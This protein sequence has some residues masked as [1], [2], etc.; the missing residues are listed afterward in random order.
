MYAEEYYNNV[1]D[2]I[3]WDNFWGDQNPVCDGCAGRVNLD[4]GHEG[5]RKGRRG[6]NK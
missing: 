2:F 3:G 4:E 5:F 6:C 1:Y